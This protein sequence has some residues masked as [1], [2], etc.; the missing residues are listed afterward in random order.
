[1]SDAQAID[2]ARQGA[3]AEIERLIASIWCDILNIPTANPSASFSELGGDSIAA[4]LCLNRLRRT[5]NHDV[6]PSAL[7]A[8][9]MTCRRLAIAISESARTKGSISIAA[10]R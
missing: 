1:M 2:S 10:E 6:S 5:I 3:V 9:G 7:L 4:G 8:D